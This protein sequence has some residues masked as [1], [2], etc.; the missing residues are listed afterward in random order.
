MNVH[1]RINGKTIQEKLIR[2]GLECP[3]D[4]AISAPAEGIQYPN[5]VYIP[6]G[7]HKPQ[8]YVQRQ[9]WQ[10]AMLTHVR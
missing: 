2:R 7:S 8:D 1:S 9:W 6:Q 3:V 5:T 4:R 10:A